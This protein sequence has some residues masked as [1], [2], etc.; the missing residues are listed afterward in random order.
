MG[1][2]SKTPSI[3]SENPTVQRKIAVKQER[4][5]C[6]E[7]LLAETDDGNDLENEDE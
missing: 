3:E 2:K 7:G 5:L 1:T 6:K 4:E